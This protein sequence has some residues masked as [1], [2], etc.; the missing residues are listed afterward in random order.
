[1]NSQRSGPP[2]HS[3]RDLILTKMP[4]MSGS[5]FSCSY[6]DPEVAMAEPKLWK[7]VPLP[8]AVAPPKPVAGTE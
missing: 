5:L 3:K 8:I 7:P 6:E 4:R 2:D 1:M